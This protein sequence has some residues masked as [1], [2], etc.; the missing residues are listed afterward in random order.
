MNDQRITTGLKTLGAWVP[1]LIASSVAIGVSASAAQA[2]SLVPQQEGEIDVGLSSCLGDGCSYLN[3]D[4]MFESIESLI[5][6]STGTRSRLFVDRAGTD[7]TYGGIRFLATDIGTSEGS[8]QY[9]FRPVAM[10]TDG[11]TTLVEE[12]QLEVG[13]FRFAFAQ[14]MASL[15]VDWFDTEYNNG[16]SYTVEYADG[17]TSN[18][19]IAAGANNNIRSTLLS[20][21]SAITLNLGQR[22]G[23]TGDGVNV[24]M[25][26]EPAETTDVPEPGIVLGLGWVAIIGMVTRRKTRQS[27]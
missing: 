23:A 16:T 12:G 25:T 13:T 3:V 14:I 21:V 26:G 18:G 15:T 8:G 9:W 17:S 27:H 20:N 5:D 7:N 22:H 19:I 11:I 2:F 4:S 6:S 10:K 1:L 24:Q